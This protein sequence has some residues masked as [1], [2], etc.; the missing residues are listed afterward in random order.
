MEGWISI[1]RQIMKTVLWR[2]E[3]KYS[4][5]K[6]WLWIRFNVCFAEKGYKRTDK[7]HKFHIKQG[8]L[9]TTK[10]KLSKIWGWTEKRVWR[11]LK[12]LERDELVSI[13]SYEGVGIIITCLD[14]LEWVRKLERMKKRKEI[15]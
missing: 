2:G 11:F 12:A 14:Y 5:L 10:K 6:A 7:G 4:K 1:Y 8:Q 9:F 13:K 3:R 15:N